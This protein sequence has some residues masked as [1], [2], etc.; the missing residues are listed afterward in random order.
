[1]ADAQAGDLEDEDG[2]AV[3]DGAACP[4]SDVGRDIAHA[5]IG[6]SDVVLYRAAVGVPPPQHVLDGGGGEDR[7][8]RG[9]R[10][11]HGG[12]DGHH[13]RAQ[14]VVVVG[15]DLHSAWAF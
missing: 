4:I 7:V 5:H 12:D 11:V 9:V 13:R 8:V 14:V 1:M 10:A 2:V 6:D 15:C 3:G